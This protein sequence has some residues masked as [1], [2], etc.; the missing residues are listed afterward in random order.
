MVWIRRAA[1][2]VVTLLALSFFPIFAACDSADTSTPTVIPTPVPTPAYNLEVARMEFAEA[3][4]AWEREGLNDYTFEAEAV[5]NCPA[6]NTPFRIT[7]RIGAIASVTNLKTSEVITDP[8]YPYPHQTISEMFRD[9]NSAL[10]GYRTASH[11][12]AEYH[13]RFNY[14][15]SYGFSFTNIEGGFV[16]DSGYSMKITSLAPIDPDQPTATPTS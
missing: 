15:V 7:V 3:K 6:R 11:F 14:P 8:P 10:N 4:D 9:I 2:L 5:C 1:L 13:S 16:V 12:R